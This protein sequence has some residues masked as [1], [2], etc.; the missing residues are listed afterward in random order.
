MVI[1]NC[2]MEGETIKEAKI[3]DSEKCKIVSYFGY[4]PSFHFYELKSEDDAKKIDFQEFAEDIIK[5]AEESSR[6]GSKLLGKYSSIKNENYIA[7]IGNR[8]NIYHEV[9]HLIFHQQLEDFFKDKKEDN[10]KFF[11]DELVAEYHSTMITE[12][13]NIY[14]QACFEIKRRQEPKGNN[15]PYVLGAYMAYRELGDNIIKDAPSRLK[16]KVNI[17]DDSLELKKNKIVFKDYDSL[18]KLYNNKTAQ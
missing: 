15:L 16:Y 14:N 13:S 11:I 7:V 12:H 6:E 17:V 9:S 2:C 8:K 5:A 4:C 3:L 1:Y 10:R 18:K